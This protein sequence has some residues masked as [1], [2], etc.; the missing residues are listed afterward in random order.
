MRDRH[1]PTPDGRDEPFSLYGLDPEK[2]GEVVLNDAGAGRSPRRARWAAGNVPPVVH[3]LHTIVSS[4][5]ATA[6]SPGTTT[7]K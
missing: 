5:T 1:N 7:T 4:S 6:S 3:T 2:V